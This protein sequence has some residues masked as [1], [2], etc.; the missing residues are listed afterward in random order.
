[1]ILASE[2]QRLTPIQ[3]QGTITQEI[4]D[5]PNKVLGDAIANQT[6][7]QF[8][9]FRVSTLPDG[10]NP[11]TGGGNANIDFLTGDDG[12]DGPNADAISMNATF[13]IETVE[14]EFTLPPFPPGQHG[15]IEV[16]PRP[17]F[18]NAPVPV[19]SIHPP[20]SHITGPRTIKVTSTQIQYSQV[21]LLNFGGLSWPHVSV[22]T[23]IP[24]S[25][26][27]LTIPGVP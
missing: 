2:H 8:Q 3:A 1:M 7:T 22:A 12:K 6:I 24:S 11:V 18:P 25:P 15:P 23:L 5:N 21:V 13:W 10:P 26:I 14:H 20:N 4:L 9:V 16:R 17:P 27:P 19:F